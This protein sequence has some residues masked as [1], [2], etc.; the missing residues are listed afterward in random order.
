VACGWCAVVN[1]G[2]QVLR[3][4]VL[5]SMT[6]QGIKQKEYEFFKTEILSVRQHTHYRIM[7]RVERRRH[8]LL[9]LLPGLRLRVPVHAQ[10]RTIL[11]SFFSFFHLFVLLFV[12]INC[13]FICY[14]VG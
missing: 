4:L 2:A 8:S 13:H 14:F 11:F 9:S 1:H 12:I 7:R 10:V 3:L 6:N 5:Y